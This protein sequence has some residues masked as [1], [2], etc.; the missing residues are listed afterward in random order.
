MSIAFCYITWSVTT[1]QESAEKNTQTY[2]SYSYW[3]YVPWLYKEL[4]KLKIHIK[5]VSF[6]FDP[7]TRVKAAFSSF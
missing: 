4:K 3:S 5:T 7:T 2:S 1:F 6:L